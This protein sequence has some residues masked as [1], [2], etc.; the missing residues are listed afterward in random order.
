MPDQTFV[1]ASASPRRRRLL[2]AYGFTF[3]V[4]PAEVEEVTP[5]HFT[6]AETVLFNARRKADAVARLRPEAVVLGVDTLVSFEG[7]IFGKPADM[8]EALRMLSLLNGQSHEV[9][10]GVWLAQG[11]RRT[12]GY[13]EKSAVRFRTLPEA[14]LR[15]Y[16]DRIGPLDKAG[17]YAAQDD[18]GTLIDNVD[19]SF[20]NVVGLPMESLLAWLRAFGV[21]AAAAQRRT[22]P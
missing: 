7:R 19:G 5:E 14:E 16:L 17:A 9:Y 15:T 21:R 2:E 13:F 1:L 20:F 6:P 4:Q 18:D 10:S 8:D 3:E 11:P 12:H 22:Q